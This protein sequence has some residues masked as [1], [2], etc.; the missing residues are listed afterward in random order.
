MQT[1]FPKEH[2]QRTWITPA[3]TPDNME[4]NGWVS[5]HISQVTRRLGSGGEPKTATPPRR[6]F[7]VSSLAIRDLD[8]LDVLRRGPFR[9]WIFFEAFPKA[10]EA[11][12]E[13]RPTEG[14]A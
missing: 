3:L 10:S 6:N 7:T 5:F 2:T 1:P 13:L 14:D 8:S 12:R 4:K 11:W 9:C